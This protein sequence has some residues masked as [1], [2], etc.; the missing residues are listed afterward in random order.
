MSLTQGGP[1][2]C[3]LT[4]KVRH[5][6]CQVT[7]ITCDRIAANTL[8]SL[9]MQFPVTQVV[10]PGKFPFWREQQSHD[11]LTVWWRLFITTNQFFRTTGD[12]LSFRKYFKFFIRPQYFLKHPTDKV[13]L[14]PFVPSCVT[15][16]FFKF[17]SLS[18]ANYFNVFCHV[19]LK[20]HISG[21]IYSSISSYTSLE[22]VLF[23]QRSVRI[24]QI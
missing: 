11:A 18:S 12:L 13:A 19:T 16:T 1:L 6:R 9:K 2:W 14:S 17:N 7:C 4:L 22:R 23:T 24:L 8:I 21:V 3:K 15:T 20:N 5:A 10:R